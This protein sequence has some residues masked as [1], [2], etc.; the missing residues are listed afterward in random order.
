M[1]V[2]RLASGVPVLSSAEKTVILLPDSSITFQFYERIITLNSKLNNQSPRRGCKDMWNAFMV[3]GA[4][5]SLGSDIPVCPCFAVN[6]PNDLI[7]YDDAKHLHRIKSK[8]DPDYHVD[9]F[10]HFY[11]DDQ[12]FDGPQS[13]I[14]VKPKDALEIVRHFSGV[15]TPDFST[16]ADFPDPLKRYNI[17]RMRAFGRWL[18]V[19]GVQIINNVR[20]GTEETWKYCFDGI[21]Y[22]SI[23]AVGTVASGIHKLENRPL[24]ENGF[25]EMVRLLHPHTIIVYGSSNNECFKKL[26]ESGINIVTFTSKTNLAF[27]LGKGGTENE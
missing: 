19:N 7:S 10:V 12:K 3:D 9:A 20:W 11:I 25:F 16:N 6:A 26:S 2:H 4:E 22:N 17:Y 15:I 18:S 23:V 8:E 5:F 27:S 24:F 14:W 21:P 13:G 1:K